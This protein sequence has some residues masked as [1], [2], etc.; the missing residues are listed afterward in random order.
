M[1]AAGSLETQRPIRVL[2][3]DDYHIYRRGLRTVLEL[4]PSLVVVGEADS[5]DQ[6]VAAVQRTEPDVVLMDIYLPGGNGVA[7]CEQ[8]RTARPQT[9]VL[10]VTASEDGADL[11]AAIRAGAVGYVLK[12]VGPDE[13][14]AAITGAAS[15]QPQ[16]SAALGRTLMNEYTALVAA[17]TTADPAPEL[18]SRE[19]QVLAL[20]ADGL[21]NKAIGAE[22]FIA[23]NTVRNHVRAILDKLGLSSRVEAATFAERHGLARR[24]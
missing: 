16:L 5:A 13:L 9:Q 6:A 12:D 18:S 3:V 11:S 20:V 15:G 23:E 21:S 10:M 22:L 8:V 24:R 4:D 1:N 2:I 19:R 7:V 14:V 17:E